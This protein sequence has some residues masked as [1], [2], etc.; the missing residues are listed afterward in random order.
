M[1]TRDLLPLCRLLQEIHQHGP[2]Q[3]PLTT[4]FNTTKMPTP[5][6]TQI[7]EGKAS[8]IVLANSEATHQ[9]TKHIALKYHHFR[10]Q[11]RQGFVKIVKVDTNYNW[12]DILTK[13]L[14]RCK[15]ESLQK[16]IM[17]VRL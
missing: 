13:P 15:H 4:P 3:L 1:A 17:G 8:C 5:A 6:T 16:M 10:D 12:A 9:H 7:F 14:T 2:V 11:I